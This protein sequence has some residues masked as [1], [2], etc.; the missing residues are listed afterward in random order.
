M[1][2]EVYFKFRKEIPASDGPEN[3]ESVGNEMKP[4]LN[5]LEHQS[6][7]GSQSQQPSSLN[8][9]TLNDSHKEPR[10]TNQ[11]A[12]NPPEQILKTEEVSLNIA[13]SSGTQ[14]ELNAISH[15][16]LPASMKDRKRKEGSCSEVEN[17]TENQKG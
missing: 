17:N 12:D 5:N 6:L 8:Q 10:N 2:N 11:K 14:S 16:N 13:D 15:G 1:V 9:L 3:T 4:T 7:E